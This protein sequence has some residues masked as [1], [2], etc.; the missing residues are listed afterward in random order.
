M[1]N[2]F[3]MISHSPLR[4]NHLKV[5]V[6]RITTREVQKKLYSYVTK[7]FSQKSCK[8]LFFLY[9]SHS[10]KL[11]S[12]RNY[13]KSRGVARTVQKVQ[14]QLTLGDIVLC[15]RKSLLNKY[16]GCEQKLFTISISNLKAAMYC[17][18]NILSAIVK[19]DKKVR[20]IRNNNTNTHQ[21]L[22]QF[23]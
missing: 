23:G 13:F 16:I 14:L 2:I 1:P 15:R 21:K 6:K 22:N 7:A 11:L 8:Y 18:M 12:I 3:E 17:I 20:S 4:K 5:I 10:S 19:T 9:H